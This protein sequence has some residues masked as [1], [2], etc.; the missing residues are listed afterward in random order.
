MSLRQR[1]RD[2][3]STEPVPVRESREPVDKPRADLPLWVMKVLLIVVA[4]G[5]VVASVAVVWQMA[6]RSANGPSADALGGD[7]LTWPPGE[8]NRATQVNCADEHLFEVVS[9]ESMATSADPADSGAASQQQTCARAV[10]QNLGPRYDPNGRFIVGAVWTSGRLMC[11]LQLPSNGVAS[12]GFK[13]RVVDQ[14]QSSVWPTGTCLGIRD[15]ETTDVA[16]DCGLPHALEI[17]GTV[18]LSTKFGQAAPSTAAQDAVVRDACGAA[19]SAYLS[20]V[21]LDA[22]GLSVRYQPVDAAG[23]AAGSRKVA[24][25]IGSAKEGGRWATLVRSAKD[26][27]LVDGRRAAATLP[28]PAPVVAPPPAEPVPVVEA[29][30]PTSEEPQPSTDAEVP[31]RVY[32]DTDDSTAAAEPVP[33]MAG[34]IVP[35]PVPHMVGSAV[36]GPAPGSP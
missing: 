1:W 34:P 2:E 6:G 4:V 9:S 8:S 28:S 30:A 15:G 31:V 32:R 18:D 26:G 21:T 17:T 5:V 22:T 11:G 10:E 29:A 25:R 33:H 36:P 19:T 3:V 13:G 14:D 23:W 7:C 24:C 12:V 16:V 27:V 20:P 35:G